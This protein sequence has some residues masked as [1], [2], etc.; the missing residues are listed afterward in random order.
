MKLLKLIFSI[1]LITT[2]VGCQDSIIKTDTSEPNLLNTSHE[3][4]DRLT[5]IAKQNSALTGVELSAKSPIIVASFVDINQME[6]SSAF[7]RII[8]EQFAS[9]LIQKGYYV[10]EL[11]LRK[12][13][14]IKEKAGEFLLSR[15]IKEI[16]ANH[17]AQGIVVGTYA[18]AANNIYLTAKIV[19]PKTNRILSSYD[20]RLPMGAD[21]SELLSAW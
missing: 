20:F 3:A 14:F 17:N 11:K 13:I 16:T 6:Q 18:V 1:A 19:D 15:K 12:N 8:A 5:S 4:V 10:V 21:S 9:R 2:L 7:G